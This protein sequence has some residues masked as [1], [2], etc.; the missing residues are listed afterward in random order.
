[1][2]INFDF[3]CFEYR[4]ACETTTFLPNHMGEIKVKEKVEHL[5]SRIRQFTMC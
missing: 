2:S 5:H 4:F 1:M 3:D